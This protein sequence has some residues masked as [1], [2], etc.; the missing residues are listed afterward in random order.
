MPE[1]KNLKLHVL[2]DPITP[3]TYAANEKISENSDS[4]ELEKD[5]DPRV[6]ALEEEIQNLT[7]DTKKSNIGPLEDGE[8]EENMEKL[9]QNCDVGTSKAQVS[10]AQN[11]TSGFNFLNPRGDLSSSHASLSAPRSSEHEGLHCG[12]HDDVAGGHYSIGCGTAQPASN[13]D[14]TPISQHGMDMLTKAIFE[15]FAKFD[16]AAAEKHLTKENIAAMVNKQFTIEKRQQPIEIENVISDEFHNSN[17]QNNIQN[18]FSDTVKTR[19]VQNKILRMKIIPPFRKE[20]FESAGRE[21]LEQDMTHAIHEIMYS[22]H[23]KFHPYVTISRTHMPYKG[24]TMQVLMVTAPS[25][26]EGD[27]ARMCSTG[28]KIFGKTVFPHGEDEFWQYVPP[29]EFPKRANLKLSNLPI[30]CSDEELKDIMKLPEGVLLQG[31]CIREKKQYEFGWMP[32]GF[33]TAQVLIESAEAENELRQW[34]LER[35]TDKLVV[36]NEVPIRMCVPRLHTC[37]LCELDKKH[38]VGHD[39]KWCRIRRAPT[40]PTAPTTT[41]GEAKQVEEATD[42]LNTPQGEKETEAAETNNMEN[43]EIQGEKE[44]SPKHP[45]KDDSG[46]EASSGEDGAWQQQDKGGKK[47]KRRKRETDTESTASST[48]N[49]PNAKQPNHGNE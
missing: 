18:S 3:L 11:H 20:H 7:N 27:I 17:P 34:S 35:N 49:P 28:I 32:T 22:F 47:K 8:I 13:H 37:T 26:A 38:A 41:E 15:A 39:A 16:N 45:P 14:F 21:K 6:V 46:S 12:G 43:M 19:R 30:L 23:P 29:S 42:E 31:Q 1:I 10:S 25:E 44:E 36:W 9:H 5:I 2:S 48:K 24:K 40:P 33:A 4:V